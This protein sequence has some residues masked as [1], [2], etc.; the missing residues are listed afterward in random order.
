MK[1]VTA[2][3]VLVVDLEDEVGVGTKKEWDLP[4]DTAP[5]G[6]IG[7]GSNDGVGCCGDPFH[8]S[9]LSIVNRFNNIAPK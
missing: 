5:G 8:V 7:I 1:G 6:L 3:V 2:V 9:I 4:P